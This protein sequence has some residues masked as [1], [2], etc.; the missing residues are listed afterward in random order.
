M[1]GLA[2]AFIICAGVLFG[3]GMYDCVHRLPTPWPIALFAG[4]LFF[5]LGMMALMKA[6]EQED[7]TPAV[8]RSP[9]PLCAPCEHNF[10][11]PE[12]S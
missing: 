9:C 4:V 7:S 1:L 11:T 5:L 2:I 12:G 3:S 8:E 6:N 10:P